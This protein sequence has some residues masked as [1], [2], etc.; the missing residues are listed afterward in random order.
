MRRASTRITELTQEQLEQIAVQRAR[1]E[2]AIAQLAARDIQEEELLSAVQATQRVNA[3]DMVVSSGS[4]TVLTPFVHSPYLVPPTSTSLFDPS[5]IFQTIPALPTQDEIIYCLNSWHGIGHLTHE[6]LLLWVEEFA[7]LAVNHPNHEY[8]WHRIG[9]YNYLFD[10]VNGRISREKQNKQSLEQGLKN[11]FE[12]LSSNTDVTAR[13]KIS[14]HEELE[15]LFRIFEAGNG[16]KVKGI[17]CS[18]VGTRTMHDGIILSVKLDESILRAPIIKVDCF[19]LGVFDVPLIVVIIQQQNYP[20]DIPQ[21]KELF[22][23]KTFLRMNGKINQQYLNIE[24]DLRREKESIVDFEKRIK[25]AKERAK[26]YEGRLATSK[27]TNINKTYLTKLFQAVKKNKKVKDIYM[28]KDGNISVITVPLF[29]IQ[30]GKTTTKEL[31]RFYIDFN[32]IG[33]N[34]HAYNLDFGVYGDEDEDEDSYLKYYHMNVSNSGTICMGEQETDFGTLL[35]EFN[36][37]LLTDFLIE[38]LSIEHD[39]SADPYITA[40]EFFKRK[41]KIEAAVALPEK[42]NL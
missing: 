31:G 41:T 21:I 24:E 11:A 37:Y 8:M 22:L 3:S 1:D 18:I 19:G 14:E 34:V 29:F 33:S 2:A 5:Y 36:I 7:E 27:V 38:F 9:I 26:T 25:Q 17:K 30:D 6:Q 10:A 4:S 32:L 40:P 39:E 20:Q 42:I 13:K 23:H 16:A 35:K 28:N 15:L 12:F